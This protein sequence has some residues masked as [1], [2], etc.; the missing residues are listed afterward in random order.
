MI[1]HTLVISYCYSAQQFY[2]MH[3]KASCLRST[4]KFD[5]GYSIFLHKAPSSFVR[6]K[7]LDAYPD[8]KAMTANQ[9][10]LKS[11]KT[12]LLTPIPSVEGQ[13]CFDFA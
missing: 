10:F 8:Q 4:F 3:F 1:S 2:Q 11:L 13:Q 7:V 9:M 6:P 12:Q 5:R